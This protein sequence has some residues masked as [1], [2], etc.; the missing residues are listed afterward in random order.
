MLN[1][2]ADSLMR[3]KKSRVMIVPLFGPPNLVMNR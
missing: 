2:M 1:L 3:E